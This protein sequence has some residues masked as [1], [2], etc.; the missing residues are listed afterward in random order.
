MLKPAAHL[1]YF[2]ALQPRTSVLLFVVFLSV[3]NATATFY[4]IDVFS[5]HVLGGLA[6][7]RISDV[8]CVPDRF[9][10]RLK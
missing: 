5:Y 8:K 3:T 6:S 2:L 4:I 1:Y 9:S 10:T 7:E